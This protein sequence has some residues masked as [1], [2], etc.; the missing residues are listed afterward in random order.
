MT[1]QNQI[2]YVNRLLEIAGKRIRVVRMRQAIAP[3]TAGIFYTQS[4]YG[5]IV[6]S[7]DFGGKDHFTARSILKQTNKHSGTTH[8][9]NGQS[10][11][12]C[13]EIAFYGESD[14]PLKL[15]KT[16][17]IDDNGVTK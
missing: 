8:S 16:G 4:G 17:E 15:M 10:G 7:C 5:I 6:P 11:R 1:E 12:N 2:D 9:I 14:C 13:K 3:Y